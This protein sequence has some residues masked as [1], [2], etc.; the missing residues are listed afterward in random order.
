MKTIMARA[1]RKHSLYDY[2]VIVTLG[3]EC[4]VKVYSYVAALI[5]S[6]N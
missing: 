5:L 3:V 6:M 4:S 2:Y 1:E